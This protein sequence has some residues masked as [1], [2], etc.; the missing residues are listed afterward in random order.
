ML[1][2]I[3]NGTWYDIKVVM[4]PGN[5]K[6]YLDGELIHDYAIKPMGISIAS[7]YDKETGDIIVKLVNPR[8]EAVDAQINLDGVDRVA[9]KGTLQVLAGERNS[10]NSFEHPDNVKT[11]TRTIK[12]GK[13][14][15]YT[16]PAMSVQFIRINTKNLPIWTARKSRRLGSRKRLAARL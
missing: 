9:E 13:S 8:E 11:E 5:I 14:F 10:A 4:G 12:V 6:C 3:E 2:H 16:L 1:G 15:P 7:T